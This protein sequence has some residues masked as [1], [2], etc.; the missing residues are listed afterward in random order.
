M[1]ERGV[2]ALITTV[3]I[4]GLTISAFGIIYVYVSPF[5]KE[6]INID[7]FCSDAQ[8]YVNDK[9]GYTCYDSSNQIVNVQVMRGPNEVNISGINIIL[10]NGLNTKTL[11]IP[12]INKTEECGTGE[13]DGIAG[14]WN[15]DEGA[16]IT[17]SDYIGSADGLING[18][19]WAAGI[20]DN[21]LDFNED[22]AYINDD[23]IFDFNSSENF[24]I[25]MWINADSLPGNA[26][27]INI[28]LIYQTADAFDNRNWFFFLEK[29][30]SI[31]AKLGFAI[32]TYTSSGFPNKASSVLDIVSGSWNHVALTKN[33]ND[34]RLWFNGQDVGGF[35]NSDPIWPP[36]S[37]QEVYIGRAKNSSFGGF[38][39]L[40]QSV[41]NSF[42]GRI[43]EIAIFH[44]ALSQSEIQE[45]YNSGNNGQSYCKNYLNISSKIP[46]PNSGNTYQINLSELSLSS[47]DLVSIA[48]IVHV[49]NKEYNCNAIPDIVLQAC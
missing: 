11:K 24:S 43:D 46:I 12:I 40:F 1:Y 7:K 29:V 2:S 9:S 49:G 28:N 31:Q 19:T 10:G 27:G 18:S 33:A 3:L 6:G 39:G 30:S 13:T 47:A 22:Y 15:L 20:A 48:P 26:S 16:G 35:T 41:G 5:V 23:P 32:R 21:S 42:D 25:A 44:N 38:N 37:S 36:A 17:F 14:Y 8:L 45:L 4:I 34:Y